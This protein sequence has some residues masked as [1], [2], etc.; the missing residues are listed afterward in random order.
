MLA[1]ALLCYAVLRCA[2]MCCAWLGYAV[3]WCGVPLKVALLLVDVRQQRG[4][5]IHKCIYICM[6][7]SKEAV[8]MSFEQRPWMRATIDALEEEY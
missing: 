3:A 2:A 1:S 6:Y 4:S 7:S 8:Y 5:I